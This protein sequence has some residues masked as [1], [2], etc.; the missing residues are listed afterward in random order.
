M[1]KSLYDLIFRFDEKNTKENWS[2]LGKGLLDEETAAKILAEG[3]ENIIDK[4]EE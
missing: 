4:E 3:Y 2:Q 1:D